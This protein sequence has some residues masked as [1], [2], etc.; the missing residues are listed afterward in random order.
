MKLSSLVLFGAGYVLG[1]KAGRQRYE[2]IVALTQKALRNVEQ[3]SARQRILDY[4]EGKPPLAEV[5]SGS[6]G[7]IRK[8]PREPVL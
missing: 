1:A 6:N 4:A 2:Q 5:F 7:G 3:M 8:S